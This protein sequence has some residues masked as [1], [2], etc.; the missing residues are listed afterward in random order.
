MEACLAAKGFAA[1]AAPGGGIY[2]SYP[3][4]QEEAATAARQA[5]LESFPD[6]DPEPPVPTEADL[7]ALL[8]ALIETKSCLEAQGFEVSDPPTADAFVQNPGMWHP[9]MSLPEFMPMETRNKLNEICP[10]P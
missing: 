3:N 6:Y 7:R 2:M 4:D 8:S 10:Q 5:C 1:E 9:Y